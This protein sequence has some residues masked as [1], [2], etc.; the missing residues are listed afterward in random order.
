MCH[1][2]HVIVGR[3][4]HAL[5]SGYVCTDCLKDGA[6]QVKTKLIDHAEGLEAWAAE[7][8]IAANKKWSLPT[9]EEWQTAHDKFEEEVQRFHEGEGVVFRENKV[10]AD[11]SVDDIPF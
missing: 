2:D 8:R 3:V 10:V 1:E 6:D 4:D 9:Y 11:L 7:L 5:I